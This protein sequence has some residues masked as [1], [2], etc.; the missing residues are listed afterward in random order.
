M[1][2]QAAPM[3]IPLFW[4]HA[5]SGESDFQSLHGTATET[6]S[7]SSDLLCGIVSKHEAIPMLEDAE[8]D[9]NNRLQEQSTSLEEQE[10]AA[11]LVNE[12]IFLG[13]NDQ[14]PS[15]FIEQATLQGHDLTSTAKPLERF[16]DKEVSMKKTM[17]MK[18][19]KFTQF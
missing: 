7:R 6:R 10:Q 5:G 17:K 11:T 9:L 8:L 4:R 18:M 14:P 19:I 12:I 13:N 1:V 3:A 15:S 16:S 2:A